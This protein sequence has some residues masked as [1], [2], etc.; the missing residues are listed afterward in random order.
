MLAVA[1]AGVVRLIANG[2]RMR[3][4]CGADLSEGDVE[5]IRKGHEQLA[6]VVGRRMKIRL[7]LPEDDYV[8]NRVQA[9]AWLVGSGQLDIQVVLPKGPDGQP[10]P[11][12]SP[13]RTT[14]PRKGSSPTP[15]GTRWRFPEA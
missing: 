3:L 9:L 1:A 14:I 10:L 2:G 4:L 15:R 5:A 8:K 7:A 12:W 11:G 6:D 13:R